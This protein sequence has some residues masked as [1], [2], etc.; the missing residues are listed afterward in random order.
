MFA[1]EIECYI[2]EV[3]ARTPLNEYHFAKEERFDQIE[4]AIHYGRNELQNNNRVIIKEVA[5]IID[6]A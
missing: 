1:R 2:V 3:Y 4:N 6:W 5:K